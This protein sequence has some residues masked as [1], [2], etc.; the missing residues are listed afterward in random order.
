MMVYIT[1]SSIARIVGK[2][3]GVLDKSARVLVY[4]I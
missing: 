2:S 3:G 1:V 4:S